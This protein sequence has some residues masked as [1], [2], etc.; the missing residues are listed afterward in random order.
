MK[1]D[2]SAAASASTD[3]QRIREESILRDKIDALSKTMVIGGLG[4]E[5]GKDAASNLVKEKWETV[6][7]NRPSEVYS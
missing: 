2:R 1:L 3:Y 4:S 6:G 7:G 5:G